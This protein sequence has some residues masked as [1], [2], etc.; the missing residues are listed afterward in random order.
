M[1]DKSEM[2]SKLI[3]S[4]DSIA[5]ALAL[6]M[7][8]QTHVDILRSVLPEKVAELKSAFNALTGENPW[9]S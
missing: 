5:H 2:L 6:P 9:Q 3:D 4:L 7:P 1:T 8:A